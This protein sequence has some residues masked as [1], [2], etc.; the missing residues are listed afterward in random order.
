MVVDTYVP[1]F[2]DVLFL[3][4]SASL[5]GQSAHAQVQH[6]SA[7]KRNRNGRRYYHR[8]QWDQKLAIDRDAYCVH[9]DK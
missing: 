3:R 6:L 2:T 8:Y 9:I 1:L 4:K 5:I 7:R